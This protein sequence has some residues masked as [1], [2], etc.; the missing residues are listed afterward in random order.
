[1]AQFVALFVR[2]V[3]GTYLGRYMERSVT[4]QRKGSILSTETQGD[5]IP[6]GYP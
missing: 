2:T 5:F 1:M 4:L 3:A 6:R